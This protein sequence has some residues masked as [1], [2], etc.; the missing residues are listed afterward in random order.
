M[1][2]FLVGIA[3]GSGSGKTA[4]A[5]AVAAAV[6]PGQATVVPADAY[7]RDLGHLSR[8]A[9]AGR[10]FDEPAALDRERLLADLAGL[11]RGEAVA[12]PNYDF[13]T[14]TR[15]ATTTLVPPAPVVLI[16]GI[17]VLA[18]PELRAL[19][20]LKVFVEAA[21]ET[22]RQRR[23]ERDCRERGRTREQAQA[24]YAA[25]TLP[26]H[27][28]HVAPCHALADLVVSGQGELAQAVAAVVGRLPERLDFRVISV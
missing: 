6:G 17:L 5:E 25:T 11:R 21:E 1:A 14:H 19:L 2:P 16:E 15:L 8:Q 23:T 3:G 27:R 13:A 4:L 18:L 28:L 9:R 7:Y 12:R 24:Q 26:M 22:R 10:N 20:E